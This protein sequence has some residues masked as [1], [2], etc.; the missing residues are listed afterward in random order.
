MPARY[1]KEAGKNHL[2]VAEMEKLVA[3]AIGRNAEALSSYNH[4]KGEHERNTRPFPVDPQARTGQEGPWIKPANRRV[5]AC[6]FADR[7][8]TRR[9]RIAPRLYRSSDMVKITKDS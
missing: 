9:G 3:E 1:D 5:G 4:F 7:D 6:G 2:G 8:S